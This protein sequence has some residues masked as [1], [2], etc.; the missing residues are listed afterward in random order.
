VRHNEDTLKRTIIR[1]IKIASLLM[2]LLCTIEL[3]QHYVMRRLDPHER[4]IEGFY[5]E[6]ENSLDLIVM[7]ASETYNGFAPAV[8]YEQ[9]GITSYLYGFS[10]CPSSLWKYQLNEIER[11]QDPDVLIIECNGACYE[12]KDQCDPSEL[13]LL[14]DDM[15]LTKNKIQ[16]IE[17]RGT[18]SKLSYYFPILK[19]H[20]KPIQKNKIISKYRMEKRGF[21]LTRGAQ[22]RV[23]KGPA[24]KNLVDVTGDESI[25][26]L[27]V[28]TEADLRIFLEE[29][30]RSNIEHIVF[31]RFPHVVTDFNY[32]RFQKYHR[33]KQI[34]EE[35]GFDYIDFDQY[36]D[37]IGLNIEEDFLD[38]E[39]LNAR[40]AVKMTRF[41]IPFLTERYGLTPRKQTEKN[42]ETWEES[43]YY[44][45]RM[46]EYWDYFS[47][48]YPELDAEKYDISDDYRSEQRIDEYYRNKL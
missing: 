34:V 10:A 26:D 47:K 14:S 18:D 23:S 17:D 7:G 24:I 39:H 30:K 5:L 3:M 22:A 31:V 21:N 25:S 12:D 1:L 28:Q 45:H 4:R 29:C 48:T 9:F 13:R 36:T 44:Y 15:P 8:A 16:L 43:T 20:N 32:W 46:Y 33:V 11:T 19:Y 2:A 37:E 40:G 35:Y 42:I 6:E 41:I 27:D 38:C